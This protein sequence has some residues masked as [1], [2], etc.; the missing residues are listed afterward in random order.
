MILDVSLA[1]APAGVVVDGGGCG[2]L[3][4]CSLPV[5]NLMRQERDPAKPDGAHHQ[6]KKWPALHVRTLD[7]QV[8]PR[9]QRRADA[10]PK[11]RRRARA[12]ILVEI[13]AYPS[14]GR[15]QRRRRNRKRPRSMRK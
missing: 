13:K 9:R 8:V 5:D 14:P 12:E 11:I 6:I 3:R 15:E 2:E 4:Y 1:A 7:I 10:R